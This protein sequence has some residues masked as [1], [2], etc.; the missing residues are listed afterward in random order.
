MSVLLKSPHRTLA[1]AGETLKSI[2]GN[3]LKAEKGQAVRIMTTTESGLTVIC[4]ASDAAGP[5]T[6]QAIGNDLQNSGHFA[7]HSIDGGVSCVAL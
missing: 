7:C 5:V 2:L 6:C 1:A 3:H 4:T